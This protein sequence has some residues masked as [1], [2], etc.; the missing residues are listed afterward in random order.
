MGNDF[1]KALG[2][3]LFGATAAGCCV[4]CKNGVDPDTDFRDSLSRKE[5]EISQLCQQCQDNVYTEDA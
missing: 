2:E 3:K 5:W 1:S 4:I